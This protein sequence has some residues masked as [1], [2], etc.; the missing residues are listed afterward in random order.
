MATKDDIPT[1]LA[2][3]IGED[4]EPRRFVAACREFFCLTEELAMAPDAGKLGW[5]VKVREGSNIVALDP[6]SEAN[7]LSAALSR[8]TTATSALVSGDFDHPCLTEK[9]IQHA[10][11]LS[12]LTKN[13]KTTVPMRIWFSKE[14]IVIGP[15]IAENIRE[16]ERSSYSDF[17][18]LEG[19]LKA[20]TDHAGGLEIRIHDPLW[21]R[22]IPCKVAD[23]NVE[24]ALS[25]FRHRVEISGLI[26]YNI[27]GRPTSIKMERLSVLPSD[28]ELPTNSDV[29]GIF[30]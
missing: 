25:A 1:D 11:K 19:T 26:N 3:E 6:V 28:D 30:A 21:A 9:A 23:G 20:I 15:D 8:M 16:L 10:K 22:P 2:L 17:G 14:P 27:S 4:L 13:G 12:D 18:T 29:M 24:D 5:R 7:V